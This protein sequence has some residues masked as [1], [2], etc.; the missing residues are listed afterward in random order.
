MPTRHLTCCVCGNYAGRWE[1]HWN[2]DTGFGVCAPCVDNQRKHPRHPVS[3]EEIERLYGVEG[4][5]WGKETS[6]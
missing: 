2:R 6:P 5:N 4:K 3:Q 1:Q